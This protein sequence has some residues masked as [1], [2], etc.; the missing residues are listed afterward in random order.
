L[1]LDPKIAL[2]LGFFTRIDSVTDLAF[3]VSH[4][5]V[6]VATRFKPQSLN[7]LIAPSLL[8]RAVDWDSI[9]VKIATSEPFAVLSQINLA[10]NSAPFLLFVP[11]N[12][13]P[14][15]IPCVSTNTTGT[16]LLIASSTIGAKAFGSAGASAIASTPFAIWSSSWLICAWTSPSWG[17]ATRTNL[18]PNFL[19]LL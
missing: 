10:A 13:T 11:M 8:R 4:S 6:C 12:V 7:P 18:T 5:A 15:L 19:L 3:A 1:S 9:P 2:M 16:P 14:L 17:G